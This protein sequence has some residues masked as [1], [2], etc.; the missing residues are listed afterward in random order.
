VWPW[1]SLNAIIASLARIE[2]KLNI[3]IARSA[4][5][6]ATLQDVQ[7]AVAAEQTVVGAVTTLL[8]Q[9]S[10]QLKD[11]LASEDPAALQAVVDSINT[12]ANSLANAVAANTPGV[13][14]S[15]VTPAPA[16]A[17]APTP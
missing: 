9:L 7:N 12:N 3:L 14:T 5:E 4:K 6:M 16:P 13:G 1:D 10:Q 15:G 8:Q 17:P 11:A 2:S